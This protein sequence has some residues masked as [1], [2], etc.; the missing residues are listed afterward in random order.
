MAV[1]VRS[2]F[3]IHQ[4]QTGAPASVLRLC[5]TQG[6]FQALIYPLKLQDCGFLPR[7]LQGRVRLAVHPQPSLPAVLP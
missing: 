4:C 3:V 2:V 5:P 6:P 1:T 7:I